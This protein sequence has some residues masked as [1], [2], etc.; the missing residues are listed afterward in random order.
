MLFKMYELVITYPD[1]FQLY[2]FLRFCEMLIKKPCKVKTIHLLTSLDEVGIWKHLLFL[3]LLFLHSLYSDTRCS[4]S[5]ENVDTASARTI[6][7]GLSNYR[8]K[9][10]S[11]QT[12]L[13]IFF[14]I[15]LYLALGH[16]AKLFDSNS[17]SV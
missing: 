7:S 13:L 9:I 10:P 17:L 1:V 11:F 12:M 6:S 8:T 5:K 14:L 3:H 2:N 4:L 15:L 16:F